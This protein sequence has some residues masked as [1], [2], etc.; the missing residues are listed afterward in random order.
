[1]AGIDAVFQNAADAIFDRLGVDAVFYPS[2]GDPISC[3]VDLDF[4]AQGEP[5]GFATKVHTEVVSIEGPRH[6]IGIPKGTRQGRNG[7]YFEIID[8]TSDHYGNKYEVKGM[9]EFDKYF[10]KASV[11]LFE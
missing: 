6:I 7:D 5:G 8:T 4:E 2:N 11:K 9:I 3:K 10:A 1:M